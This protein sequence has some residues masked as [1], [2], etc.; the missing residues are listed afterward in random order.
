MFYQYSLVQ[1]S[2]VEGKVVQRTILYLGSE[3][4]LEDKQNRKIVLAILKSKIFGQEKLFPQ[5]VCLKLQN[6]A[7]KYYDKYCINPTWP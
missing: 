2:R 1:A 6:L 7:L 5:D 4:L 3:K